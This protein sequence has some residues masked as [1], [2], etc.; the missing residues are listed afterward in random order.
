MK[1][2]T[3]GDNN[4]TQLFEK[5]VF[6]QDPSVVRTH[7][8]KGVTI[9]LR[10]KKKKKLPLQAVTVMVT[11]MRLSQRATSL[12]ES[13]DVPERLSSFKMIIPNFSSHA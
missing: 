12:L 13:A 11:I 5:P 8:P 6:T 10:L 3:G 1:G 2:P 7:Y 4:E 9:M